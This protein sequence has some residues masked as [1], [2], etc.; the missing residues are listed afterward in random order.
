M[1]TSRSAFIPQA[2]YAAFVGPVGRPV[3]LVPLGSAV[4]LDSSIRSWRKQASGRSIAAGV[5]PDRADRSYLDAATRLRRTIWDPLVSC[6]AGASRILIVPD[7]LLNLVNLAALPDGDGYLV[8]RSPVIHYLTTE[9]DLLL[10]MRDAGAPGGLLTV[11]GPAFDEA[12]AAVV[13]TAQ[14][15]AW[16]ANRW[17]PCISKAC[18]GH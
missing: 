2:A 14:D 3:T 16:T 9:R 17:P 7:G 12:P 15:E 6:L 4:E 8:E 10:P 13:T 11:G 1:R 5:S 18:Q